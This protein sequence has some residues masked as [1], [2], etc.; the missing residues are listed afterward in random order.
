[1]SLPLSLFSMPNYGAGG[2]GGGGGSSAAS[3]YTVPIQL[4]HHKP[5]L[6]IIDTVRS[7]LMFPAAQREEVCG[8]ARSRIAAV[9]DAANEPASDEQLDEHRCS[10]LVALKTAARQV[11]SAR[12]SAFASSTAGKP[13]VGLSWGSRFTASA[14]PTTQQSFLTQFAEKAGV[15]PVFALKLCGFATEQ[16]QQ[17]VRVAQQ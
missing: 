9:A 12:V 5:T 16:T 4:N 6:A 3:L 13:H 14:L 15:P 11:K 2:Y 10:P 8:A 7:D 1:M 17:P